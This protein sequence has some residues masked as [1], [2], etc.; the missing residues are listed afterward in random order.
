[1]QLNNLLF[2]D[3]NRAGIDSLQLLLSENAIGGTNTSLVSGLF[4]EVILSDHLFALVLL[5][6]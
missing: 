6:C 4:T 1:M 5:G 3:L 2:V